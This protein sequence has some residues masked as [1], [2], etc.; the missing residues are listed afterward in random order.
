MAGRFAEAAD[1]RPNA[2][3]AVTLAG[4]YGSFNLAMLWVL[5]LMITRNV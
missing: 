4:V 1:W 3:E 5:T 2:S